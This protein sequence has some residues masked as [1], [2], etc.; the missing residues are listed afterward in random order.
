MDMGCLVRELLG[1]QAEVDH[2]ERKKQKSRL[3]LEAD[4]GRPQRGQEAGYMSTRTQRHWTVWYTK[5]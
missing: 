4:L 5:K 1:V 2:G 3:D